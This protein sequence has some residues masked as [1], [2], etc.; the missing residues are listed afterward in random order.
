[1]TLITA[2]PATVAQRAAEL[3]PGDTLRLESGRYRDRLSLNHVRGTAARPI[4]IEA[5]ADAVFDAGLPLPTSLA[6]PTPVRALAEAAARALDPARDF[7][8]IHRIQGE[9]HLALREC[10]HLILSGLR[11][12]DCWPTAI[13]ID[14]CR[15][16]Q[17]D[18]IDVQGAAYAFAASGRL[19]RHLRFDTCKWVQDRSKAFLWSTLNFAD[20]HGNW[21]EADGD[22][23]RC[24]D[25]SF[26]NGVDIAGPVSFVE[27]V[28]K[29]AFNGVHLFNRER[30]PDLSRDIVVRDCRFS[31]VKDN[32][33]EAE[34][35]ATNWWIVGNDFHNCHKWLS[36]ELKKA[37]GIYVFRNQAWADDRPGPPED[38]NASGA[39]FKFFK[40]ADKPKKSSPPIHVFN[41]SWAL[42][43]TIVAEG[44]VRGLRHANNAIHVYGPKDRRA[45]RARLAKGVSDQQELA[46]IDERLVR[47]YREWTPLFGSRDI[48]EPHWPQPPRDFTRFWETFDIHFE[49]D[50]VGRPDGRP[51]IRAAGYP[52][53]K[54]RWKSPRFVAPT[55]GDTALAANSPCA[56]TSTAYDVVLVDK[57][58]VAL[59]AGLNV[60]AHQADPKP[61]DALL[62]RAPVVA[63]LATS[64]DS[65]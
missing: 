38:A 14:S 17:F 61:F 44:F 36:L 28:V 35:A 48:A 50:V 31:H 40:K 46:A 29:H 16:L 49:N 1:M 63:P 59:P 53:M 55:A 24:F 58:V 10:E 7:P 4:R 5:A 23:W 25:G 65:G 22:G 27:C 12:R 39:V 34:D 64:D 37:A 32:P 19:T 15:H 56:G 33:V 43:S 20:V 52:D 62:A 26:F 11:F 9:G 8:G 13:A 51:D 41:N 18:A 42:R 60:G 57:T 45:A 2:T 21:G 30:S 47:A 54:A 3:R 6:D